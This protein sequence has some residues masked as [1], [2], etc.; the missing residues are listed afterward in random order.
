MI[1]WHFSPMRQ[2]GVRTGSRTNPKL[3][4]LCE[5]YGADRSPEERAKFRRAFAISHPFFITIGGPAAHRW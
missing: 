3:T 1:Y 4:S 5:N 2:L